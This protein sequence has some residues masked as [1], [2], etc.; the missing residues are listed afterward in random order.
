[1]ATHVGGNELTR[2]AFDGL[3]EVFNTLMRLDDD[4]WV[5][6]TKLIGLNELVTQ[7]EEEIEIKEAQFECLFMV[8]VNDKFKA[9]MEILLV[10]ESPRLVDKMKYVFGYSRGKDESFAGLMRD[11]CLSLRIL[12]SK[13]RRLVAEL[14]AV[15]EV[16]GAV[17]CL[18]NMRV[19]VSRD[20]VTLRE[21]ETLVGRAQVGVSL[22]AGF[23]ADMEVKD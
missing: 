8:K 2:Q 9:C 16:E 20:A 19:I 3:S 6:N 11:L 22:K 21:F 15:G 10:A 4:V 7:V 23:V 17:K 13:K 14:E 1:M 18:E 5:E 12:L